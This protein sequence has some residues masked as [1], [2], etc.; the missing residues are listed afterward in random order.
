M[1]LDSYGLPAYDFREDFNILDNYFP[2]Y[3][4]KIIEEIENEDYD[5]DIPKGTP[6]ID[7]VAAALHYDVVVERE[8]TIFKNFEDSNSLSVGMSPKKEE[9][10][11]KLKKLKQMIEEK[12][13]VETELGLLRSRVDAARESGEEVVEESESKFNLIEFLYDFAESN[14]IS[15][16]MCDPMF[17]IK[18]PL[19]ERIEMKKKVRE[20]YYKKKGLPVPTKGKIFI[21]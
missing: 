13:L 19:A 15:K 6:T 12:R 21:I 20:E 4:D 7:D 18:Y 1:K 14:G 17:N 5:L 2:A 10:E 11:L 9:T 8:A 3:R 16:E